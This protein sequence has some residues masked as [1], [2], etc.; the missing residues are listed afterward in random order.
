MIEDLEADLTGAPVDSLNTEDSEVA[1]ET[2]PDESITAV[3]KASNEVEID[4][5]EER[6]TETYKETMNIDI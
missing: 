4:L 3:S 5:K 2:N 6:S 1:G